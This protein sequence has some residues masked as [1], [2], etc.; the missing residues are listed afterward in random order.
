MNLISHMSYEQAERLHPISQPIIE[1]FALA[2]FQVQAE[3]SQRVLSPSWSCLDQRPIRGRQRR[4]CVDIW[5]VIHA[6]KT[7]P[8][9]FMPFYPDPGLGE[10]QKWPITIHMCR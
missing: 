4:T 3:R 10:A 9:G 6:A 1:H 2:P 7:K 8:F 5:E